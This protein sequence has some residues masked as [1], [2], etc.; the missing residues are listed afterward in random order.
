MRNF[1]NV[2]KDEVRRLARKEIRI[3][4]L[5]I[6]RVVTGQRREISRLKRSLAAVE[7]Q[8]ETLKRAKTREPAVRSGE[9]APPSSINRFSSRSVR[10]QRRRLKLSAAQFGQLMG[11]SGQTIYQWEQGKSRPRKSQFNALVALR[12]MGRREAIAQLEGQE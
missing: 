8:L 4:L 1:A 9:G 12:Q 3:E 6:K 5:P 11:V 10:A 2:L 7:K